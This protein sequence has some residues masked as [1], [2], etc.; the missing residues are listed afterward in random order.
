[1]LQKL[2]SLPGA[3]QLQQAAVVELLQVAIQ[4]DTASTDLFALKQTLQLPKAEVLQLLE[5]A[6]ANPCKAGSGIEQSLLH[7]L[8][9]L[10][11]VQQMHL[12]E[13]VRAVIAAIHR[14]DRD[15]VWLLLHTFEDKL[16]QLDADGIAAIMQVA[17]GHGDALALR[18][19]RAQ[20]PAARQVQTASVVGLDKMLRQ[21]NRNEAEYA[22]D[23]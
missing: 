12:Q 21:G 2:C 8:A 13:A 6:L 20:I 18:W 17:A 7:C 22:F 1:M 4:S 10:P 16:K 23:I 19:L 3:A 11:S 14:Q 5:L 15:R 9:R